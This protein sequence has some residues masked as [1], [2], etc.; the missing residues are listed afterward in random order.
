MKTLR[1]NDESRERFKLTKSMRLVIYP[2][3]NMNVSSFTSTSST[4]L[5]LSLLKVAPNLAENKSDVK[6]V[7][8][9]PKMLSSRK[10]HF[11]I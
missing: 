11:L 3:M 6:A 4:K 1:Y 9:L 10:E 2:N 5:P 8:W 7:T